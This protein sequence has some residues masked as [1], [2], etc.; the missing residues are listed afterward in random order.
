MAVFLVLGFCFRT[1]YRRGWRAALCERFAFS[2]AA[3]VVN[4]VRQ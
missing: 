3:A 2:P 4:S 1:A